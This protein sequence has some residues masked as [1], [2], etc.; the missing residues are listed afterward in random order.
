[1]FTPISKEEVK[2]A[3]RKMKSGKAVGPDLMNGGHNTVIPL[4]NKGDAQD[5]NNYRGIKLLSHTK[6]LW[7]RIIEGKVKKGGFNS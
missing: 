2:G 1:V 5:C 3:F 6:K 7:K 4:Y